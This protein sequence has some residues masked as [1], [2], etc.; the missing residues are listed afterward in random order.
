[1]TILRNL[2]FASLSS[3]KLDEDGFTALQLLQQRADCSPTL[4]TAFMDT[5]RHCQGE[6]SNSEKD[7]EEWQDAVETQEDQAI[8]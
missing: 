3:E 7:A 5:M 2:D 6:G 1:M 8:G 4:V